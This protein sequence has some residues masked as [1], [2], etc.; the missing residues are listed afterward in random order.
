MTEKSTD[1]SAA[2]NPKFPQRLTHSAVSDWKATS[3]RFKGLSRLEMSPYSEIIPLRRE[4]RHPPL[5]CV[6][7]GNFLHMTAA[8]QLDQAVYG[9]RPINLDRANPNFGINELAESHVEQIL[10]VQ[11]RGP[12]LL[13]GY[14]FGGLV[15]FEMAARLAARGEEVGLLALV[16]TLHPR[17]HHDLSPGEARQFRRTYLTDRMKKYASN[18]M[19]GRIRSISSDIS[20]NIGKKIKPVAWKIT[21]RAS[22]ALGRPQLAF[23][24]PLILERMWQTYSPNGHYEGRVVLFRVEK[25]MGGGLEFDSDPALGWRKYAKMGVDVQYVQ[26]GH[27]TVMDPPNVLNLVGKLVPYLVDFDRDPICAAG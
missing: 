13:I 9:L 1:I 26:G 19:H 25:A 23:A 6:H 17:F 21:Q 18:V 14:S 3:V 12:Y 2:P 11:L 27:G 5:F 8:M 24:E 15:A 7:G 16:D 10:T 4:G 20:R 22:Q